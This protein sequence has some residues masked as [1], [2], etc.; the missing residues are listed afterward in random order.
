[1]RSAELRILRRYATVRAAISQ[2]ANHIPISCQRVALSTTKVAISAINPTRK[3]IRVRNTMSDDL[4]PVPGDRVVR[5]MFPF[6]GEGTVIS[7]TKD[8]RFSSMFDCLVLWENKS[9]TEL[10]PSSLLEVIDDDDDD[11][12]SEMDE[13]AI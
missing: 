12:E 6:K 2:L 11:D 4:E 1:M 3:D 9:Y 7:K 13:A 8:P 10:E 5:T